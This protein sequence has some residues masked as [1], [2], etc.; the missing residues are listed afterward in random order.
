MMNSSQQ[1]EIY[2]SGICPGV[3][4]GNTNGGIGAI[5]VSPSATIELAQGYSNTTNARA[6]LKAVIA[7]LRVVRPGSEVT[8]HTGLKFITDAFNL[9][10]LEGWRAGAW[11]KGNKKPVQ[12]KD[13]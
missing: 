12:N 11:R 1:I 7:A 8:V 6:G 2:T 4:R 9:G 5:V 10:W 3:Q 13:L